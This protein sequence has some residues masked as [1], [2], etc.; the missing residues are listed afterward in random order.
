MERFYFVK[1]IVNKY[2][3]RDKSGSVELIQIRLGIIL[4]FS[5]GQIC[6]SSYNN[7]IIKFRV[8]N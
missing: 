5:S 4:T 3:N 6:L 7:K 8:V 2:N 1:A